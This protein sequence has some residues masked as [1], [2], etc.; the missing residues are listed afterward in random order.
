M[1][2]CY[3][4]IDDAVLYNYGQMLEEIY[5]LAITTT[6]LFVGS[7][8][9]GRLLHLDIKEKSI[10]KD[11][12]KIHKGWIGSLTITSDN[13]WLFT[14]SYDSTIIQ[15]NVFLK[16][17]V[18]VFEKIHNGPICDLKRDGAKRL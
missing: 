11:Y 10:L 8:Y 12:G 9:E 18:R 5:S 3:S 7:G 16:S 6:S 1:L 15:I 4:L 13:K 17:I 2:V 14:G